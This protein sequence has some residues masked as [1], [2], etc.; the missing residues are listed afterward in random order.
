MKEDKQHWSFMGRKANSSQGLLPVAHFILSDCIAV[1]VTPFESRLKNH[2][3]F[4]PGWDPPF[5]TCYPSLTTFIHAEESSA[6]VLLLFLL[7]LLRRLGSRSSI[8][9]AAFNCQCRNEARVIS[10]S[11]VNLRRGEKQVT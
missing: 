9:Q 5:R 7:F 4:P 3:V 11:C 6:C 8:L 10:F 2:E 1:S